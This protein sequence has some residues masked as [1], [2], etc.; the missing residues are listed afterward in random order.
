MKKADVLNWLLEAPEKFWAASDAIWETPETAFTEFTAA[1]VQTALLEKLGFAVERDVAGIKT[2][3]LGRWGEGKPVIGFL[4]EFDAL[5]GLSQKAGVAEQLPLQEGGNGHGCGHNLLGVGSIA[6]AAAVKEYLSQNGLPGT[7]I[8]YGCPGEEGGSGKAFMARDHVFDELDAAISWHP[9]DSTNINNGSSLANC[10]VL[11]RF[12]GVSA[13]AAGCPHLGRSA[14]DAVELMNVGVQFLREHMIPDA[15]VHYAITDAGGSSPNVVQAEA[16][17]LYLIRSP[18]NSQVRELHERVSDIA[19]GAALMTG[20]VMEEDF[21]KACSGLVPNNTLE[22]VM[23]KNMSEIPMPDYTPEEQAFAAAIRATCPSHTDFLSRCRKA[24]GRVEGAKY[25]GGYDDTTAIFTRPLP[26]RPSDAIHAGSTDV[27][28]VSCVCPVVQANVTTMAA[29]TPGHSWQEV[30]Q[31][32]AGPAHKGEIYA[33]QLMAAT[34]IDLIHSPETIAAA[35]AELKERLA[36]DGGKYIPPIPEGVRPRS[37]AS[38]GK[39]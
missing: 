30:A 39:K 23:W 3:F 9:S 25:A 22:A 26:Y 20:T 33:A 7:V 12:K 15:R 14:L 18:K 29:D 13:H 32:K 1:G 27:G 6:A 31:G 35:Q 34:A 11:Y 8:Y 5:S 2:A 4:G 19:K 21:V 36:D 37:I 17:V 38:L 28:D 24:V 16:E 10:Q